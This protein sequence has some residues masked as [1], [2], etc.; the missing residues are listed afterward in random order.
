MMKH[1]SSAPK[2]IASRAHVAAFLYRHVGATHELAG[3]SGFEDVATDVYYAAPITWMSAYEIGSSCSEGNFCPNNSVTRAQA[4]VFIYKVAE[5]P[6]AW[7]THDIL[8]L[9][10]SAN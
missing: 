3:D 10:T 5:T 2:D 9:P 6:S 1:D 4:A 8:R 7:G